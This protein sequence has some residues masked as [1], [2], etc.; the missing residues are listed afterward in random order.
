[1][2]FVLVVALFNP[3]APIHET[4]T[5]WIFIDIASAALFW[6]LASWASHGRPFLFHYSERKRNGV[7]FI[8]IGLFFLGM[9]LTTNT[10]PTAL[11]VI[12]AIYIIAGIRGLMAKDQKSSQQ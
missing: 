3:V 4:K 2:A 12:A 9:V 6:H 7:A 8:A 1:M 5:F 11:L 10:E